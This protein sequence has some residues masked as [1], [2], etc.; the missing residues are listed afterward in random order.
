MN[1]E[2]LIRNANEIKHTPIIFVL[3]APRSGTTLLQSSLNAHPGIV[4]PPES[5]FILFLYSR[6]GKIRRF[7]A[8]SITKFVEALFSEHIFAKLW[9]LDK[10]QIEKNLQAIGKNADFATLCKMVFYQVANNKEKLSLISD[11]NPKHSL[12]AKKLLKIYPE[13]RFI[14]IIRDPRDNVNSNM[15]SL[16]KKNPIFLAQQWLGFN[17]HIED[18]KR[19]YPGKFFTIIYENMVVEPEST[20]VSLCGFLG[21]PYND[22]MLKHQFPERLQTYED[23]KF[24]EMFK[25]AHQSMLKP[26]NTSNLGKWKEGMNGRE[27]TITEIF[28]ATFAKKHYGYDIELNKANAQ[29]I[30]SWKLFK[31][32]IIYRTWEIFTQSRF[33]VYAINR[34]YY[35]KNKNAW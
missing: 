18:I 27:K 26:I 2:T 12:F 5:Y 35:K 23:R 8:D 24:Y 17:T 14:H 29:K 6:F 34:T 32:R 1:S 20:F 11:K 22:S 33:K 31:G 4:A 9:G 7:D 13:A 3:G 28:T 30:S 19:K 16:R 15:H 25:T 10:I 21:V